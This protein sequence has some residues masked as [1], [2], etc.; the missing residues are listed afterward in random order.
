M[1]PMATAILTIIDQAVEG[2][3]LSAG[4][5]LHLGPRAGVARCLSLLCKS[6][7]L[8]RI[9]RG[10]YVRRI[11]TR[12]GHR[13]PS[14]PGLIDAMAKRTGEIIVRQGGKCANLLGLTLQVPMREIFLTSGVSRV[15]TINRM[16]I[17]LRHSR[18]WTLALGGGI[19]GDSARAVQWCGKECL[20]ESL[21]RLQ[22]TLT[23]DDWQAFCQNRWA[24][25]D[26][27]AT[28]V[29]QYLTSKSSSNSTGTA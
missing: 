7:E 14:I 22:R 26:W 15:L 20:Q 28:G 4:D 19:V 6:G 24:F 2:E 29:L 3:I 11:A 18:C 8:F 16:Q 27:M 12:F 5:L 1:N 10:L 13:G 25:P 21:R 23:E 9:D 17:E